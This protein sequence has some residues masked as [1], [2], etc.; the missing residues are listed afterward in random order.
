M[1]LSHGA[2]TH[3]RLRFWVVR[4]RLRCVFMAVGC[5]ASGCVC[6]RPIRAQDGITVSLSALVSV[7]QK[8]APEALCFNADSQQCSKIK[9]FPNRL[10][11]VTAPYPIVSR[12]F[13]STKMIISIDVEHKNFESASAVT[14]IATWFPTPP[15]VPVLSF[16]CRQSELCR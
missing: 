11:F 10:S 1:L 8:S 6:D 16:R 5:R 4:L 13:I 3:P 2:Y 7:I 15:D 14:L 12:S 9:D